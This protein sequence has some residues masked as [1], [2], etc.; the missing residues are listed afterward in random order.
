MIENLTRKNIR[1]LMFRFKNEATEDGQKIRGPEAT[2]LLKGWGVDVSKSKANGLLG[3]IKDTYEQQ[4]AF[5]GWENFAGD[6][7][8]A[9]SWDIGM[10]DA[11]AKPQNNLALMISRPNK[12]FLYGIDK[13]LCVNTRSY[14]ED[15]PEGLNYFDSLDLVLSKGQVMER[16]MRFGIKEGRR[17]DPMFFQNDDREFDYE[18]IVSHA[19]DQEIKQWPIKDGQT[20]ET[21]EEQTN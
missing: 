7:G 4:D 21:T 9:A 20:A 6:Y 18:A 19:I 12:W 2:K 14:K 5:G 8:N 13:S 10:H 16:Q 15:V 3:D 1:Y 11:D 17:R